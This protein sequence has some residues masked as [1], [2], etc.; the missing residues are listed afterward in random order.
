MNYERTIEETNKIVDKHIEFFNII[1]NILASNKNCLESI[2]KQ[3]QSIIQQ[4]QAVTNE[5]N[6]RITHLERKIFALEQRG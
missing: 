4:L 3:N 2:Y 1:E 6:S 5:Y